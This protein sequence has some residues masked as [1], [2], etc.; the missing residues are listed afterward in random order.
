MTGRWWRIGGSMFSTLVLLIGG[1]AVASSG[2]AQRIDTTTG[3]PG[4]R[5]VVASNINGGLTVRGGGPEVTVHRHLEWTL[6]EPWLEEQR[7]GPTLTLRARCGRPDRIVQIVINCRVTYDIEVPP[8]T[9]LDLYAAGPV[10]VTGVHGD[11]RIRPE[12]GPAE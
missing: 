4:V 12:P 8:D 2:S 1:I 6:A 9:A 7:D 5:R 3:F 10:T 11:V